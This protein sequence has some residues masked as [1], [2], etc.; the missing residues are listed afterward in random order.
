M[1]F[2]FLSDAKVFLIFG[3]KTGWI[4]QQLVM[5]IQKQG[6]VAICASSRLENREAIL[7]EIE[8]LNPDFIINA[9]GITGKPNVDWC[10]NHKEETIRTNVLGALN[11]AD[12]TYVKGIHL[13]NISTGCIYEYDQNHLLNSG[14]GFT[15]A[16]EPNFKGSFYSITKILIEKLICNYP[17]VLHLRLRMPIADDLTPHA[18]IGK[19]VQYKKLVNIPNSMA[20]MN[21]LLPIIIDMT[22]KKCTGIYNFVNPGTISHNEIM[23]LYKQYIDPTH[24]YENFTI[25]EQAQI[26]KAGRSNCE[27]NA[28][29]LLLL[30]P[31]IPHI[32]ESIIHV[33]ERMKYSLKSQEL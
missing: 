2:F 20:I 3:G 4:G 28:T 19:I 31:A 32:K 24:T 23:E 14:I 10:E 33:F 25:E 22:H 7:A 21:D 27:L 16:E 18:F 1:F 17:N 26:L 6:D 30:Y 13:T 5:L 12:I 8:Q 9:A 29:K 11:L 15:E